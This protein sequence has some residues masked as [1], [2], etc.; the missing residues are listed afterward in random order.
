MSEVTFKAALPCIQQTTMFRSRQSRLFQV[1]LNLILSLIL[2]FLNSL[3]TLHDIVLDPVYSISYLTI[4]SIMGNLKVNESYQICFVVRYLV[5][6]CTI[7]ERQFK[8]THT[9]HLYLWDR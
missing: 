7:E 6:Q 2:T 4:L 3:E 8:Q 1:I 9:F 5:G